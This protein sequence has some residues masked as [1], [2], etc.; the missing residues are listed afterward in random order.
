MTDILHGCFV[1]GTDTGVG[2]TVVVAALVS[3]LRARGLPALPLKPVQ[4]GVR[5]GEPGDLDLALAAAGIDVDP[6]LRRLLNP[7]GFPRAASPHLAARDAGAH[8]DPA[9]IRTACH[10]VRLRDAIPVVEGAGGLRVPIADTFEM[11]DLAAL[12]DLPV[13]LVARAG[14]GTLNH[15]LLSV[16][17]LHARRIPPAAVLLNEGIA[18]WDDLAEDNLQ[19]LRRQ[20]TGI[21]VLRFPRVDVRDR[22]RLVAACAQLLSD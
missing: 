16:E 19:T 3:A 9:L 7:Y 20:L 13:V 21:R 12:L 15:T 8:I 17:A 1:A 14:L 5:P 18:P 11:I 10:E 6:P 4:T 2:K 22:P